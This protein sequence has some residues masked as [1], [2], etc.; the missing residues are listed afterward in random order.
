M[1]LS[2]YC[3]KWLRKSCYLFLTPLYLCF[4]LPP[5]PLFIP[6]IRYKL[7]RAYYVLIPH[8]YM[9]VQLNYNFKTTYIRSDYGTYQIKSALPRVL[10][11]CAFTYQIRQ[12]CVMYA[13]IWK[14]D[15]QTYNSGIYS[16]LADMEH[17][18]GRFT[19]LCPLGC[20][21]KIKIK[22]GSPFLS[23]REKFDRKIMFAFK[24]TWK[25][26]RSRLKFYFKNTCK[27]GTDGL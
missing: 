10:Q 24:L 13:D 20:K 16:R 6:N 2:S 11:I 8:Q 23:L 12:K 22:W 25:P 21:E 1:A 17:C 9:T 27:V 15:S 19:G 7:I 4:H 5:T 3:Y 26:S 18:T 14:E